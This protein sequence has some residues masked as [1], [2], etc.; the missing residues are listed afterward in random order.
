MLVSRGGEGKMSAVLK[1]LMMSRSR[2]NSRNQ[3][4]RIYDLKSHSLEI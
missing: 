2:Q 3:N 4:F 1:M